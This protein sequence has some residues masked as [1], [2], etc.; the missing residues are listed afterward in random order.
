LVLDYLEQTRE[1]PDPELLE[2]LQWSQEDLQRFTDRWRNIR[3]MSE[4]S[5]GQGQAEVEEALRSLGLRPGD[6]GPTTRRESADPLRGIRDAGNRKPPPAAFRDAFDAFR[7]A[8]GQ[9][10]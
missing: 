7:R 9:Q 4:Q 8:V 1:A 10:P 2:D 6:G 5:G 3:E